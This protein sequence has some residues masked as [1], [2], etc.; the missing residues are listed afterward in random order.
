MK[1]KMFV[2][3]NP[4]NVPNAPTLATMTASSISHRCAHPEAAWKFIKFDAGRK[5]SIERAKVANW[6]PMRNDL[7]NDPEIKADPM[8][9]AVREDRR[10]T[11]AAIRCP[12]RSGP[13]SRRTTSSTPCR[14][15]C[16]RRTRPMRSSATSTLQADEEAARHLMTAASARPTTR[17]LHDATRGRRGRAHSRVAVAAR[18]L[19]AATPRRLL[20]SSRRC[21]CSCAR[22]SS[23]R[24]GMRS[25]PACTGCAG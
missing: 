14:R 2:A 7:A 16:S 18:R 9:A 3:P 13:T 8:L 19:G 1:G 24:S 25:G 22:S 5:W 15:R 6:M 23:S 11:R 10:R 17:A 12:R 21:S 20:R 4:A